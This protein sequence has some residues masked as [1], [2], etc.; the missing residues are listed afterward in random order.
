MTN[1]GKKEKDINHIIEDQ[2][3]K[4]SK[5]ERVENNQWNNKKAQN[6]S[7]EGK[8]VWQICIT[9]YQNSVSIHFSSLFAPSLFSASVFGHF[10]KTLQHLWHIFFGFALLPIYQITCCTIVGQGTVQKNYTHW[11]YKYQP[12]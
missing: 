7:I 9:N 4:I 6:L 5:E 2:M 8:T 3:G 11:Y 10:F 1:E 12:I